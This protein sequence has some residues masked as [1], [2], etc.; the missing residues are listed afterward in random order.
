MHEAKSSLFSLLSFQYFRWQRPETRWTCRQFTAKH[1]DFLVLSG[2]AFSTSVWISSSVIE[3][4][5]L[6]FEICSPDGGYWLW[7]DTRARVYIWYHEKRLA[8]RVKQLE[9][10]PPSGASRNMA[11]GLSIRRQPH[12]LNSV[13]DTLH[14]TISKLA[15]RCRKRTRERVLLVKL[16]IVVQLTGTLLI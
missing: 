14:I 5:T 3:R 4:K 7:A 9:S 6:H 11:E 2:T 8:L 15:E 1:V 16:Y 10:T 12:T 13:F